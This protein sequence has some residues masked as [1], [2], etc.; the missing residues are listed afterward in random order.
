MLQC[1]IQKKELSKAL[2]FVSSSV[3][4]GKGL[5][6]LSNV[7][8]TSHEN[9]IIVSGNNLTSASKK[10]VPGDVQGEGSIAIPAMKSFQVVKEIGEKHLLLQT[11]KN[12]LRFIAGNSESSINFHPIA[13]IPDFPTI[14]PKDF[15]EINASHLMDSLGMTSNSVGTDENNFDLSTLAF[16]SCEGRMAIAG[17][18]GTRLTVMDRLMDGLPEITKPA[19]IPVEAVKAMQKF[20][21]GQEKVMFGLDDEQLVLK[22][23]TSVLTN[24]LHVGTY[25]EYQGILNSFQVTS[26]ITIPQKEFVSAIK[27]SLIFT[28]EH[29]AIRF[30]L[31]KNE[32]SLS[33]AHTDMG[34]ASETISTDYDGEELVLGLNA[35]LILDA[36]SVV[37]PS[38]TVKI[39]LG[40]ENSPI[41]I[42]CNKCS[43]YLSLIMPMK[44]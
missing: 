10:F 33:S 3:A 35:K 20:L 44:I 25:P 37:H 5:Q 13:E 23:K 31:K 1:T 4:K 32:L 36:I 28:D 9:G 2:Q 14:K 40:G 29:N 43:E 26:K 21:A 27:R 7:V 18:N 30:H 17:C 34:T 22:T 42:R 15:I 19:L 38:D 24:R 39:S 41:V 16:T 6:S 12:H 8:L 11:E